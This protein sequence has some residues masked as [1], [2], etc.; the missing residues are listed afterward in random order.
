MN[1]EIDPSL[2]D[3]TEE[4]RYGIGAVR[5]PERFYGL[6]GIDVVKKKTEGHLC[7]FVEKGKMHNMFTTQLRKDG[8]GIDYSGIDFQWKD[9][10][11][12]NDD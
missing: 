2:W 1:P 7:L 12:D 8:M 4:E 5:T 3:H 9:P 6:F 10:H 11:A